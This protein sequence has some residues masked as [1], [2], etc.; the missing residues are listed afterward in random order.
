MTER[1][2]T[3]L[4]EEGERIAVP[5]PVASAILGRGRS[6]RTRRRWA[7]TSVAVGLA[8]AVAVG[9]LAV[10]QHQTHG[11]DPAHA[12]DAFASLGAFAIGH[13]LYLGDQLVHF[14]E[15]I[16]AIFYTSAGVMVRTGG[17][18]DPDEGPSTFTLV[19]ATGERSEVDVAMGNRVAGFE[20]DSTRFA[21][22]TAA[23]DAGQWDVVVHDAATDEELARVP[24]TGAAYGGWDAPPVA[25][26]GDLA[27]IHLQGGW[28]EVDWR[29]GTARAVPDTAAT[30][31]VQNGH[32]AVQSDRHWEIR[33]MA[34]GSTVGRVDLTKGWYAFFSPDGQAMRAFPDDVRGP[35]P[36]SSVGYD[37]A[38]GRSHP[39]AAFGNV[40][41]WTPDGH[42]LWSHDGTVSVCELLSDDCHDH[43]TGLPSGTVRLGGE[44]YNS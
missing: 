3:L 43:W 26:D 1:L 27:W 42:L 19:S 30:F 11:V 4:R 20:P 29:T 35:T 28:T 12:A 31:E 22:A 13:E 33:S 21:Y 18:A 25:I 44:P 37:V 36:V 32:Y 23:G 15:S 17:S 10:R 2:T 6:L 39:H 8:A 24:V 7:H 14:D 5:R 41:G 9:G 34:D 38:S 16:K 40:L